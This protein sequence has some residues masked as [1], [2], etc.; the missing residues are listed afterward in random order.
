[1]KIDNA[2][3]VLYQRQLS[4]RKQLLNEMLRVKMT[5]KKLEENF[6]KTA[7]IQRDREVLFQLMKK[8]TEDNLGFFPAD[9]DDFLEIFEAL[10]EVDLIDFAIEIYKNDRMGIIVSPTYLTGYVSER[11]YKICPRRMLITE[12]EKHLSGLRNLIKRFPNTQIVL[13][14][15]LKQMYLL[16][17]LAFEEYEHVKIRFESIYRSCLKNEKYDYICSLPVF[18]NRPEEGGETFLTRDSDGIALENMLKH[19]ET[20]GT[21]DI[22]VPAKITFSNLGYEKLRSHIANNFYVENIYILPEGTFRPA[23]AIKTYLF[24]ITSSPKEQVS[25]GTFGLQKESLYLKDKKEITTKE[26]LS[27]KDWR[28]ELPLADDNENIQRFKKSDIPKVKLK[29]VAEVFRGKSVLKKDITLG[30]VAVLNIS[31]INDGEID[32][33]DLDTINEEEHKIKRYELSSGDVVL[34]CRGTSIKSAVFENQDTRIIA[35]ANLIVIRPKEKVKGEFIKIFLES[36]VGQ[37]M[38]QS[39][40]RGTI[41]ININYADIMEMEIP[42]L[43]IYEQQKMIETYRQEFKTYKE[44][45]NIAES[46]WENV[47]KD[48]YDNLL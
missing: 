20:N 18:S 47:K 15:Q 8:T 30:N 34:S 29:N 11:V 27:H 37:A 35:S 40:Q 10:K 2:L 4:S 1:M 45:I 21:L 3:N 39:F 12:A 14:T 13:T 26:F 46:R 19:L 32:Y 23:T 5:Q 31:N 17:Q 25:I 22:I 42:L 7:N 16:L 9:R 48:I 6:D 43:P 28:I 38:I 36:P 41:I 33:R 24:S 44:A